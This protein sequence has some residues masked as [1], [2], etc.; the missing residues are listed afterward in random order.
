MSRTGYSHRHSN[1]LY[2]SN[3]PIY[4]CSFLLHPE[5]LPSHIKT[6]KV[7]GLG[8]EKSFIVSFTFNGKGF[9]ALQFLMQNFKTNTHCSTQFIESLSGLATIRAFGWQ[10]LEIDLNLQLLNTSQRPFYLL[11]MIQRWLTLVLDLVSMALALV[12]TGLAVK[13]RSVVSPGFTGVALVNVMQ[14]NGSLQ[15][16]V[17]VCKFGPSVLLP[18]CMVS[19]DLLT[20]CRDLAGNK[21]WGSG[22]NQ[23]FQLSN[24]TR[25]SGERNYSSSRKLAHEG[26]RRVQKC[27]SI[28]QVSLLVN[29]VMFLTTLVKTLKS[30]SLI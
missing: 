17:L 8:S 3:L 25:G 16:L 24:R 14:F 19:W 11:F 29:L 7:H 18:Q 6:T 12:V 28:I 22:S 21:Y 10:N 23:V 30:W 15:Q 26:P 4:R 2:C 13:L 1:I 20:K 9:V 27:F 5:I